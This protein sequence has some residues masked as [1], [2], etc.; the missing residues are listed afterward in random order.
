MARRLAPRRRISSVTAACS[1]RR[2]I[3]PIAA[4]PSSSAVRR[5][6][7]QRE[8]PGGALRP[9]V[10]RAQDVVRRVQVDPAPQP[11]NSCAMRALRAR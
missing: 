7:Q 4:K 2:P 9:R 5:A 11:I 1:R 8:A 6:A 10:L 3:A